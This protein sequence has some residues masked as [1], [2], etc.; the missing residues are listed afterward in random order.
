MFR[1][2]LCTYFS[3]TAY[4]LRVSP[5]LGYQI[6]VCENEV[7]LIL[8]GLEEAYIITYNSARKCLC[9]TTLYQLRRTL[10]KRTKIIKIALAE[11]RC[12]R[13]ALRAQSRSV[14]RYSAAFG[15][16]SA[17]CFCT[18]TNFNLQAMSSEMVDGTECVVVHSGSKRNP[19]LTLYSPVPPASTIYNSRILYF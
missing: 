1:L 17:I 12:E 10:W 11:M 3:F 5:W 14:N 6:F 2:K 8:E 9:V 15:L 18:I 19:Y 7:A 4:M 13:E 16:P